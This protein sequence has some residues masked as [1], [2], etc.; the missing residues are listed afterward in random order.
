MDSDGVEEI[1]GGAETVGLVSSGSAMMEV[2]QRRESE[3]NAPRRQ[4]LNGLVPKRPV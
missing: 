2:D 3:S 1:S 4:V